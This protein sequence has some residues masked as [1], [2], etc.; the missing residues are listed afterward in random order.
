MLV[1]IL[2]LQDA[3][4]EH[5]YILDKM[6]VQ[7]ILIKRK[8]KLRYTMELFYQVEKVQLCLLQMKEFL[9]KLKILLPVVDFAEGGIATPAEAALMIQK[10]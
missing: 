9:M 10:K 7:N 2:A 6:K 8:S 3:F 1:G 5:K 4:I